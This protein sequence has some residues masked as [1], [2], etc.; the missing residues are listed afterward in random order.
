M[1]S[2]TN[3]SN[4]WSM[5]ENSPSNSWLTISRKNHTLIV[6]CIS[7][8]FDILLLESTRFASWSFSRYGTGVDFGISSWIGCDSDRLAYCLTEDRLR[9][10]SYDFWWCS[11]HGW[12]EKEN[13]IEFEASGVTNFAQTA[14]HFDDMNFWATRFLSKGDKNET[15]LV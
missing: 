13:I 6:D 14:K 11:R 10:K 7:F 12:L 8:S 15:N 2:H 1:K 3:S 4:F 5:N 9:I